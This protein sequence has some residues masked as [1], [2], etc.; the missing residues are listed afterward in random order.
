M[1]LL[2]DQE[3]QG[4]WKRLRSI[5][6]DQLLLMAL[7]PDQE[8]QGLWKRLRSIL[9]G[10]LLLMAL[11]PVLYR[12]Y[13]QLRSVQNLGVLEVLLD[14]QSKG[15]SAHSAHSAQVFLCQEALVLLEV[16]CLH[17][18]RG[19]SKRDLCRLLVQRPRALAHHEVLCTKRHPLHEGLC[20]KRHLL[21]EDLCT[22]RHPLHEV[23]WL[24]NWPRFQ[25]VLWDL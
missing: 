5:L 22:K 25:A 9:L 4:L 16:L 11:L 18:A 3:D 21:H 14:P 2:P 23:L 24:R 7:L 10:Q 15:H 6:L 17:G 12:L 8:D 19:L 1:A 20:T 13:T